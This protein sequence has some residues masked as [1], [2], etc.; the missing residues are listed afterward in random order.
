MPN[1]N[2][3]KRSRDIQPEES[4]QQQPQPKRQRTSP[5]TTT[6][7]TKRR[8]SPLRSRHGRLPKL[9]EG[10]FVSPPNNKKKE[11]HNHN[12]PANKSPPKP[13]DGYPLDLS[14][15]SSSSA[16]LPTTENP[17]AKAASSR[18]IRGE[19][20]DDDQRKNN[21]RSREETIRQADLDYA[22]A[23]TQEGELERKKPPYDTKIPELE[24]EHAE[25][26]V[27]EEAIRGRLERA[28]RRRQRREE[29]GERARGITRGGRSSS[30]SSSARGS[31]LGGGGGRAAARPSGQQSSSSQSSSSSSKN[32]LDAPPGGRRVI[33]QP[34]LIQ[35]GPSTPRRSSAANPHHYS[36]GGGGG[37]QVIAAAAAAAPSVVPPHVVPHDINSTAP[38]GTGTG[39]GSSQVRFN[40]DYFD[41]EIQLYNA[42]REELRQHGLDSGNSSSRPTSPVVLPSIPEAEDNHRPYQLQNDEANPFSSDGLD[43]AQLDPRRQ[44]TATGNLLLRGN[45][46]PATDPSGFWAAGGPCTHE[47]QSP[48]IQRRTAEDF[49]PEQWAEQ[50]MNPATWSPLPDVAGSAQPRQRSRNTRIFA[51]PDPKVRRN[52]RSSHV[53]TGVPGPSNPSPTFSPYATTN[54]LGKRGRDNTNTAASDDV[55]VVPNEGSAQ[56][57]RT[58][59]QRRMQ[60]VEKE[61]GKI[62]KDNRKENKVRFVN[63]SLECLLNYKWV[64]AA[65]HNDRRHA[66][67]LR[68]DRKGQYG[69]FENQGR[70]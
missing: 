18:L 68:E 70:A 66:L 56:E 50:M 33:E 11:S 67:L 40:Y 32:Q 19:E 60:R 29:L 17:T 61:G 51:H 36:E 39:T 62:G 69:T 23:S 15:S 48:R 42:E 54:Q 41:A 12:T 5:S 8:L 46:P 21:D 65:Y 27:R 49:L 43:L 64:P 58:K 38:A 45:I 31:R 14:P 1:N 25:I 16:P 26:L 9:A 7:T 22:N 63:G 57:P 28:R 20:E 47:T 10:K 37:G 6:T 13:P 55:V 4:Q 35:P 34:A 59:R 30:S 24:R 44:A 2:N 52:S 53:P 3:K